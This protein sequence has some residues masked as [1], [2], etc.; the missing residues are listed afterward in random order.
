MKYVLKIIILC[1]LLHL[2]S[3]ADV[4]PYEDSY[5]RFNFPNEWVKQ[6]ETQ[7][8]MGYYSLWEDSSQKVFYQLHR[9]RKWAQWHM[10]GLDGRKNA[11]VNSW[12]EDENLS[13]TAQPLKV[14]YDQENYILSILWERERDFVVSK[15]RLTAFGCMAFHKSVS[16]EDDLAKA[17]NLLAKIVDSIRIPEH[18]EF[19]P[20]DLAS[21]LINNMGGAA[22]FVIISILYIM[23]SLFQ[24]SQMRHRRMEELYSSRLPLRSCDNP[25]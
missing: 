8:G 15:M 11:F 14:S 18:L 21:E 1:N 12:K 4:L 6:P 2:Y 9:N 23:F 5:L 19:Y 25:S 10:K 16:S 3:S 7:K 20:E 17:E 24:R 22:A 13:V